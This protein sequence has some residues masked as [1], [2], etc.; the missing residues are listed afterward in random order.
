MFYL[1]FRPCARSTPHAPPSGY[2]T[3]LGV[4]THEGRPPL[5][6]IT[7]SFNYLGFG[8]AGVAPS[9]T[10]ALDRGWANGTAVRSGNLASTERNGVVVDITA[11][12]PPPAGKAAAFCPRTGTAATE[13][14]MPVAHR[15][16]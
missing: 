1:S 5:S 6:L 13:V 8:P 2:P 12:L 9:A 7:R 10:M 15:L 11:F 4:Q 3:E 16:E 14:Y